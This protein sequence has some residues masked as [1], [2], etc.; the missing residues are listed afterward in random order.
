MGSSVGDALASCERFFVMFWCP[1]TVANL[2]LT[3]LVRVGLL[4]G[5]EARPVCL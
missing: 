2:T 5:L 4:S 3:D 1:G